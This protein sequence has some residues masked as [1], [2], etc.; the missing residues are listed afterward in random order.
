MNTNNENKA[1]TDTLS[2]RSKNGLARCFGR[3][4]INDPGEI[5]EAGIAKLEMT[6][7]LGI[8]S[9]REIAEALHKF[10]YIDDP[11]QWLGR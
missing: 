5:A 6:N 8:K 3:G 4:M 2:T 11:D 10:G 1:F 9:F 7:Q